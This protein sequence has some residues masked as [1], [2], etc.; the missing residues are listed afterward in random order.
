MFARTA[1]KRFSSHRYAART[2]K[3]RLISSRQD[4]SPARS[5]PRRACLVNSVTHWRCKN[6]RGRY[7]NSGPRCCQ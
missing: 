6:G 3:V 1:T 2:K 4:Q 5:R 7:P